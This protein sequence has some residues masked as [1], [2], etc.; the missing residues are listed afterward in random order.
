MHGQIKLRINGKVDASSH[1]DLST[2]LLLAHLPPPPPPSRLVL[3]SRY[4]V[5]MLFAG[6]PSGNSTPERLARG[7]AALANA[8]RL[9][10]DDPDVMRSVGSFAYYAHRDYAKAIAQFEKIARLQ[11]ND[12]TVFNALGVIQRRQ[13]RQAESLANLRKAAELDPAGASFLEHFVQIV[14][15]DD[16]AQSGQRQLIHRLRRICTCAAPPAAAPSGW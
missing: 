14:L 9:V 4:L 5:Y 10:P 16:V 12:P 11:P 1:G 13:G 3:R 7:E 6:P 8:V 2:Q 15:A